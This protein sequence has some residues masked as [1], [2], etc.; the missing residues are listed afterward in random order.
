MHLKQLRIKK[1][2]DEL[3]YNDPN[4]L[5]RRQVQLQLKNI[6]IILK[7]GTAVKRAGMMPSRN[8]TLFVL[9]HEQ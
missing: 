3:K 8:K 6:F 4:P 1:G 7:K 2:K 9:V 5:F